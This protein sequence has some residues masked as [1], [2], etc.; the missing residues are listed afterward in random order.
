MEVD[1]GN[2]KALFEKVY[3]ALG[4]TDFEHSLLTILQQVLLITQDDDE[5]KK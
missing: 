5:Q 4:R 3:T 1:M 2:T